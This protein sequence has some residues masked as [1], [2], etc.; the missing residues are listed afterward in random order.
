MLRLCPA[1]LLPLPLGLGLTAGPFVPEQLLQAM[2]NARCGEG[3]TRVK[4]VL[5]QRLHGKNPEEKLRH[6][7]LRLGLG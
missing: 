7:P 2:I 6:V 3:S 5:Q 1:L 4:A